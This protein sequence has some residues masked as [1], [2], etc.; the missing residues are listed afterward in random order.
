MEEKRRTDNLDNN[1]KD[2]VKANEHFSDLKP[3]YYECI[4]NSANSAFIDAT[5]LTWAVNI[6]LYIY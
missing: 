3:D 6:Y 4:Q 5:F 2:D 1:N